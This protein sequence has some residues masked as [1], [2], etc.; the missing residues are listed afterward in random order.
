M[1]ERSESSMRTF[2]DEYRDTSSVPSTAA[3]IISRISQTAFHDDDDDGRA[4]MIFEELM[5]VSRPVLASAI[6]LLPENDYQK[7]IAGLAINAHGPLLPVELLLSV[8]NLMIQSHSQHSSDQQSIHTNSR[9][10]C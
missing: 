9:F 3:D 10:L 1:K 4:A 7:E 2:R 6:E 5:S 8:H